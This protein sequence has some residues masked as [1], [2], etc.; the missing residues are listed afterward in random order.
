MPKTWEEILKDAQT[1]TDSQLASDISSLSRLSDDEIN[2]IAPQAI[3]KAKLTAL[4]QTIAD[5]TKS[6]KEKA[7][8][9]KNIQGFAEMAVAVLKKVALA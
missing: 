7:E 1:Q 8:A 5:A 9:I 3:D 6:N 4:M 2:E